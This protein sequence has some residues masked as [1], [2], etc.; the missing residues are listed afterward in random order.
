MF[1]SVP[2]ADIQDLR[3]TTYVQPPARLRF[4]LQQA[5]HAILRAT[6]HHGPSSTSEPAWKVLLLSSW[7]LLGR[8]AENASDANCAS[9][10]EARLGLFWSGDWPAP[11]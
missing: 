2:W 8:P 7:L 5:K 9:I 4:A 3:G 11:C 6:P 10:L 1:S